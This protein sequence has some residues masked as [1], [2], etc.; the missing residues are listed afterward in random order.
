MLQRLKDAHEATAT[1][2]VSAAL[3]CFIP[4][5]SRASEEVPPRFYS[6]LQRTARSESV[7]GPELL[8][9]GWFRT[10]PQIGDRSMFQ[11]GNLDPSRDVRR[12]ECQ[13]KGG[14]SGL[15]RLQCLRLG[16]FGSFECTYTS[17]ARLMS[18][19]TCRPERLTIPTFD[20]NA[21]VFIK[22]TASH[23]Q[24]NLLRPLSTPTTLTQGFV[25]ELAGQRCLRAQGWPGNLVLA[26]PGPA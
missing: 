6:V 12:Q 2:W 26:K 7:Q 19:I 1:P 20:G 13:E 14:M 15:S 5:I 17:A 9:F 3:P 4:T 18:S 23:C 21:V 11:L 25:P 24:E 8:D 16:V 22:T 10:E